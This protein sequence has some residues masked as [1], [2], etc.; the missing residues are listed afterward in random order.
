MSAINLEDDDDDEQPNIIVRDSF[1]SGTNWHFV[2]TAEDREWCHHDDMFAIA[3]GEYSRL[4]TI[5][6]WGGQHIAAYYGRFWPANEFHQWK[7]VPR[8]GAFV[9]RNLGSGQ[10]LAQSKTEVVAIPAKSLDDP[11]CQWRLVDAKTGNL[12][13]VLYDSTLSIMPPE[14]GGPLT[15]PDPGFSVSSIPGAEPV[16]RTELA[17]P[18]LHRQFFDG[19]KHGHELV[20]EMLKSGYAS[21]VVAPQLVRGW[22]NGRVHDIVVREEETVLRLW[23]LKGKDGFDRC[24]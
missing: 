15:M 11:A 10:L 20:R 9:F 12:C 2:H 22:K 17:P 5:D 23:K 13:R 19:L 14:L 8:D 7:V 1:A 18:D 24:D 4:A 21:L 3:A 16:I 6:H